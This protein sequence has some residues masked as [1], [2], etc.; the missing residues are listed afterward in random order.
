MSRRLTADLRPPT[1]ILAPVALALVSILALS[2]CGGEGGQDA[3]ADRPASAADAAALEVPD[4]CRVLSDELLSTRFELAGA[5]VTRSPSQYSPQPLCM[6]TWQDPASGERREVTLTVYDRLAEDGDQ[7]VAWFEAA[8]RSLE[9]GTT[10]EVDG[11]EVTMFQYEVEPMSGLGD[12][13]AWVEG[14]SQVSVV[15]GVVIY[16]VTVDA[17]DDAAVDREHAEALA[18]EIGEALG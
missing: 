11:E 4:P 13:A 8:M 18:R 10:R 16:H 2:G 1:T 12:R 5:E 9:Q 17:G 14:L 6:V 15:S 3:S 7:A